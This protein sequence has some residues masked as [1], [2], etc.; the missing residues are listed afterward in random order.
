VIVHAPFSVPRCDSDLAEVIGLLLGDGCI[1]SYVSHN[2]KR[3]EI[4][5]TGNLSEI[6]YY[7]TFVKRT[8]ERYFP[9]KGQLVLRGDNTVRLHYKS[10][11]LAHFLLSIGLP[12]GKKADAHIPEFVS[13]AGQLIA[14]VRGFYHAEG[15]LYR[16]YSKRYAGHKRVYSN[17][18]V[19]QFRCKLKTLMS[20]V[21][22]LL[23]Q[24]GLGPNRM[25]EKDGAFTFRITN[26]AYIR[27][28][29]KLVKPRYKRSLTALG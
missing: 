25:G 29:F 9:L 13:S 19:I 20:Q 22:D 17:L 8:I 6:N 10:T 23:L 5:F 2:R 28:F 12:L 7:R 18:M 16:R 21:R 11:R 14:F 4:A 15:S 26:Q 27:L 1:S 3:L 24:L